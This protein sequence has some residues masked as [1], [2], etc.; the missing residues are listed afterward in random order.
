L[1]QFCNTPLA[2]APHRFAL[3]GGASSHTAGPYRRGSAQCAPSAHRA[4]RHPSEEPAMFIM[5]VRHT[6]VWVWGVLAALVALGLSQARDREMSLKRVMIVPLVLLALSAA[7]VISAFGHAP[8]GGVAVGGWGAS[9]A[10][11]LA[12]ARHFVAVRGAAWLARSA[13]LQVP[14]SWLPLVLMIALFGLKYFVGVSLALHPALANDV[15]FA[16]ACSLAYGAFSGLFLGRALSL[17]A[18]ARRPAT[19]LAA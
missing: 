10:A 2:R 17:R 16:G 1:R 15:A 6:P 11:A 8:V 18:L 7:G 5:I 13:T 9:L 3:A 14:G 4:I 12:L 19:A